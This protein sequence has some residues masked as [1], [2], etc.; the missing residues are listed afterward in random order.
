MPRKPKK[1]PA[2]PAQR[3]Q[4]ELAWRLYITEGYAANVSHALAVN[5]YTLDQSALAAMGQA[6]A[7]AEATCIRLRRAMGQELRRA[8]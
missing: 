1:T 4:R 7:G 2:T 6:L 3:R 8:A 5:A